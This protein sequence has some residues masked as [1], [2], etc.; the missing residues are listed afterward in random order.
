[1][2]IYYYIVFFIFGSVFGSFFHVVATRMANEE[3][4][5]S[6]PS[7][8]PKCNHRLKWYELIPILSYIIQ[9]GK[10]KNCQEK[11]PLSYLLIEVITG[12]LFLICYKKF[13]FTSELIIALIFVSA[14]VINIISDIECMII[15][16]E[17]LVI[18]SLLIV[19]TYLFS[20]GFD[21]TAPYIYSAI[22]SFLTM[23]GIKICGDKLFKKESLGGGDIKLMFLFGLVNGYAM[24]V[25]TIFLSAFIALPI[26]LYIL[27]S[28]K[29]NIIPFGPFLCMS[30]IIILIS[31]LNLTDIINYLIR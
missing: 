24:S 14:M 22:G 20:L 2:K 11:I 4:I 13:G 28:K 15:I 17:V 12:I 5:I 18:A 21:K 23:Y 6:P 19:L 25:C 31:G 1:M 29:D 8:C 3:S 26:A 9:R 27:L 16:D 7:F 10:C 30:S